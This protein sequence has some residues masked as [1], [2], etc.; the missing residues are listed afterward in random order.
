M[1][2]SGAV[3]AAGFSAQGSSRMNRLP[4]AGL[5]ALAAASERYT[6]CT[7]DRGFQTLDFFHG[8]VPV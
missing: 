4:P 5:K 3:Q 2:R 1:G 7:L 6:L 8:L